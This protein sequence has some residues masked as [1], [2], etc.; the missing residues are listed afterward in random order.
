MSICYLC[1]LKKI[2]ERR[3]K[4]EAIRQTVDSSQTPQQF[5][6]HQPRISPVTSS[7]DVPVPRPSVPKAAH[8]QDLEAVRDASDPSRRS[9][10]PGGSDSGKERREFFRESFM[11]TNDTIDRNRP[12]N[13]EVDKA[14]GKNIP[15]VDVNVDDLTDDRCV[16][17]QAR[18]PS[19]E[20]DFTAEPD[21]VQSTKANSLNRSL[22]MAPP[23]GPVAPPRKKKPT[24]RPLSD[25]LVSTYVRKMFPFF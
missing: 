17:S 16:V 18:T 22:Q 5:H 24:V 19:S 20:S 6:V 13:I 7:V 4:L 2:E 12:A 10:V 3:R 11:N 23:G 9:S 14:P 15:E 8:G 21:I 1:G 25:S